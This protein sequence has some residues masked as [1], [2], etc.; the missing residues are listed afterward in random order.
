MGDRSDNGTKNISIYREIKWVVN[1][2]PD[3]WEK[4][5]WDWWVTV[6]CERDR[7]SAEVDKLTGHRS[8]A[9]PSSCPNAEGM[10]TATIRLKLSYSACPKII[11]RPLHLHLQQHS[12]H[13]YQSKWS[14]FLNGP[15][16]LIGSLLPTLCFRLWTNQHQVCHSANLTVIFTFR[17]FITIT[18]TLLMS[19]IFNLLP[20]LNLSNLPDLQMLKALKGRK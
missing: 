15:S 9:E 1:D 6:T 16:K 3:H 19:L 12:L 8:S 2:L 11:L 18:T 13:C 20:T 10:T 4:L 5:I 17:V 14:M 7:K